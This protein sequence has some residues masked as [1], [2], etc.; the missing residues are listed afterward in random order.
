P[1]GR[2]AGGGG[3]DTGHADRARAA[4]LLEV[5]PG[6]AG[7]SPGRRVSFT[8]S[9][10]RRRVRGLFAGRRRGGRA[11]ARPAMR[12]LAPAL[13][14]AVLALKAVR[15][16]PD[17]ALVIAPLTAVALTALA[18]RLSAPVVAGPL[19]AVATCALLLGLTIVPRATGRVPAGIGLD[20][21]E[22]PL[23]AIAF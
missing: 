9:D 4:E 5:A 6:P 21:R 2:R 11:G 10:L 17:L 22:L 12:W 1:R 14:L 15:F 8:N 16:A 23:S 19:P 18:R 13:P 3:G 7:A 20:A